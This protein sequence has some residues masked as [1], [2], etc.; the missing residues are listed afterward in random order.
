MSNPGQYRQPDLL[1]QIKQFQDTQPS[2]FNTWK[3]NADSMLTPLDQTKSVYLASDL[4]VMGTINNPSDSSLKNGIVPI[5]SGKYSQILHVLPKQYTF[6]S[7]EKHK[8]HYGFIAQDLEKCYP[9]LVNTIE[10]E[11]GVIKG[12]N[13]I[14]FIPLLL[15]K[16]KQMQ[17][18]I[19]QLKK[20]APEK[21]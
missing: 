14:E 19:D 7:D 16:M 6:K 18:E 2:S 21:I 5:E 12:V 4:Y 10:T 13:Y 3:Y 15:G 1:Q 8:L 17:D 11:D 9:E 20:N